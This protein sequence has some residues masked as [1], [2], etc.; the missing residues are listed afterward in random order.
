MGV[1]ELYLGI[2][3]YVC[4]HRRLGVCRCI[5]L[6]VLVF[7]AWLTCI[8]MSDLSPS[9][10]LFLS[11]SKSVSISISM[12]TYYTYIQLYLTPTPSLAQERVID[13]VPGFVKARR[14]HLPYVWRHLKQITV[15]FTITLFPSKFG[16]IFASPYLLPSY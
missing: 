11:L 16:D 15:H 6:H 9:L 3:G 1:S 5:W 4:T 8:Y 10:V 12:C 2:Q 7:H 13:R 14:V